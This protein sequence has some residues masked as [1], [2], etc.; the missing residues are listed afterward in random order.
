MAAGAWPTIKIMETAATTLG[1]LLKSF[2]IGP[3]PTRPTSTIDVGTEQASGYDSPAAAFL[4]R[5]Q[6]RESSTATQHEAAPEAF[7]L[8]DSD[9]DD[10]TGKVPAPSKDQLDRE[11]VWASHDSGQQILS[12]LGTSSPQVTVSSLIFVLTT[13]LPVKLFAPNHR[14]WKSTPTTP[15]PVFVATLCGAMPFMYASILQCA[16]LQPGAATRAHLQE[17]V[18]HLFGVFGDIVHSTF[19]Y[20]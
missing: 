14:K 7:N 16:S 8:F 11:K 19:L 3:L 2:S 1:S 17:V 18:T 5:K 9:S 4:Q 6:A 20:V 10:D 12:A 15:L 13:L